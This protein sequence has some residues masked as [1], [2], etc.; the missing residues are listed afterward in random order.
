MKHIKLLL[1]LL[2]LFMVSACSNNPDETKEI[3]PEVKNPI[4][5]GKNKEAFPD[6]TVALRF[7]NDGNIKK[8]SNDYKGAI[9]DYT[10]AIALHPKYSQAYNNR[11]SAEGSLSDFKKA[12]ADFN[13]AVQ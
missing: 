12:L 2:T 6:T 1:I 9:E 8:K 3:D 11:G 4:D 10:K 7:Y 5:T 13:K